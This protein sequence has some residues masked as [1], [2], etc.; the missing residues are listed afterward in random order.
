MPSYIIVDFF[1]DDDQADIVVICSGSS[2][3]TIFFGTTDGGFLKG[4]EYLTSSSSL[5]NVMAH[6]DFNNDSRLDLVITNTQN[7]SM[8][9]FLG[10]GSEPFAKLLTTFT[11]L[12]SK[13]HSLAI[14]D[15]NNDNRS[16]I[17]IANYG[18][19]NIGILLAD[20]IEIFLNMT[21]YSSGIGSRPYAV[22]VD[23]F[24][25]DHQL[26]IAVVNSGTD[27]VTIFQ[28]NGDGS[29]IAI[30]SYSTGTGSTP[31]AIAVSD[32]DND[33]RM[34]LAIANSGTN[35]LLL[36]FGFGNGRFGNEISYPMNYNSNPYSIAFGNFNNDTW[37]D[38]AVAN[39]GADYIETLLNKC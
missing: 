29:F 30:E 28:G 5:M 17:V 1:N 21:M 14:G 23:D 12:N 36:L 16:D 39:N 22:V 6:G 25:N 38:I 37:I 18:T 31:Y 13:P 20:E 2:A 24:N 32:F 35:N 27:I 9:V 4:R 15:F 8:D 26:D 3:V 11:Y 10:N 7:D 34:D 19:D 33:K